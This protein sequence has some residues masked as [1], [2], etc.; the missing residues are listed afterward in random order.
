MELTAWPDADHRTRVVFITR[1]VAERQ[2]RDLFA[3]MRGLAKCGLA[4][5]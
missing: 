1:D 3:A 5:Q 4:K 2:V